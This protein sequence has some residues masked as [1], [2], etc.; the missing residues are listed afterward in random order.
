MNTEFGG[1]AG[2]VLR[3]DLTNNI[4]KKEPTSTYH[5][6]IGG[7]GIGYKVLWDNHKDGITATDEENRLVISAGPLVVLVQYVQQEQLLHQE[8]L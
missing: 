1:W 2:H 4:I 8:A 7:M 5:N 6:Y 3:V